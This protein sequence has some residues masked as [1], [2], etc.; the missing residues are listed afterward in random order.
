MDDRENGRDRELCRVAVSSGPMFP[1]SLS[2]VCKM[3]HVLGVAP[4]F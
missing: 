4:G 1:I 2:Y 3:T